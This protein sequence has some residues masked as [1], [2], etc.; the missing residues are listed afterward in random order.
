MNEIDDL[1]ARDPATLTRSERATL[2]R[3]AE[4]RAERN[5]RISA[6]VGKG[7]VAEQARSAPDAVKESIRA[8]TLAGVL[9]SI[10]DPNLEPGDRIRA[11]DLGARVSGLVKEGGVV[12]VQQVA[13][14]FGGIGERGISAVP[15]E[16]ED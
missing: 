11:I 5:D 3:D 8:A 1:R 13:V 6:I 10:M 15:G 14:A 9:A 7:D 2:A 16:E 12:V 4:R